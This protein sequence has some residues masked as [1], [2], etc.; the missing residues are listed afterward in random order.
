[1]A[2]TGSAVVE[3]VADDLVRITGV[4]LGAG[5]DGTIG[6]FEKT[7]AP[8]VRLPESFKPRV[9]SYGELD[10]P[11]QASMKVDVTPVTAGVAVAPVLVVKTGDTPED[12]EITIENQESGEGDDTGDLEIYVR[13]H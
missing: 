4:S 12:F 7:V 8:D 10:V 11:L 1:M 13:F 2:F 6:L 5:A 3:Q 9:Y